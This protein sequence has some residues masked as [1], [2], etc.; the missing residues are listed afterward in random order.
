MS[1]MTNILAA[2]TPFA[3]GDEIYSSERCLLSPPV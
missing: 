3:D 2:C 1:A